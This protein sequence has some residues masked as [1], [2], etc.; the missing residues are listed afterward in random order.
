VFSRIKQRL[1]DMGTIK[2]LCE[3]A[4]QHALQDQQQEPGIEHFLLSALDLPDGTARRAFERVGA[5]PSDLPQAI[6]RQYGEALRAVGLDPEVAERLTRNLKPLPRK[7]GLYGATP[8]GK[9]VM[10]KL[11]ADRKHHRPLLGAHVVAAVAQV[12]EGVAARA[13][14]AM[15]IKLD[16]LK[17]A[18]EAETDAL[19]GLPSG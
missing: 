5:N 6:A 14:R 11:A 3:R 15:G 18:A 7:R 2:A 17:S 10:Q 8:S 19:R 12:P 1:D 4:E 13:L 9:E 16:A